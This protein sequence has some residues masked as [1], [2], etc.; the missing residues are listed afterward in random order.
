[1]ASFRKDP[2]ARLDYTVD[3]ADWLG[4]TDFIVSA[5]TSVQ[6]GLTFY[7]EAH[8]STVHTIWLTGGSAGQEYNVTSRIFTNAGRIDDR[9]FTIKVVER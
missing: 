2:D 1:M 3:W 7:T 5:A 6:S 4:D 9:S 8:T